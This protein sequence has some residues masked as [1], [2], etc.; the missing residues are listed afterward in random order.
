MYPCKQTLTFFAF[1]GHKMLLPL[2]TTWFYHYI[3]STN[4]GFIFQ[5]LAPKN[6]QEINVRNRV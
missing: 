1:A 6:V 2:E 5:L 4:Y 3:P